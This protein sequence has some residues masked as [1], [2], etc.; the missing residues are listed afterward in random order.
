MILSYQNSVVIG[1]TN[2]CWIFATWSIR[3][4]DKEVCAKMQHEF[5]KLL[6]AYPSGLNMQKL[7]AERIFGV[8][9]EHIL[10]GN[11]ASELIN[12]IGETY[13]G[14][15]AV[16]VPTFNEYVRCFRN[17]EIA[18]V[19]NSKWD[20]RFDLDEYKR[21]YEDADMLCVVS[22]DNPSGAMLTKEQVLDLAEYA[23]E[24]ERDCF[25]MNRLSI[26]R[27]LIKNIR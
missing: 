26:L 3:I 21:A 5:P 4:P 10:V 11:G 8:D 19:D 23:K 13:R 12:A 9:K 22:P 27:N 15:I 18:Y 14:K 17:C 25:W 7:N 2:R 24:R 20:Y 16:G 6:G 1:G